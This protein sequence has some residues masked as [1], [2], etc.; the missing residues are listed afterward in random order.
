MTS[1]ALVQTPPDPDE[2]LRLPGDD[3]ATAAIES[4]AVGDGQIVR[5]VQRRDGRSIASAV[6]IPTE[7][8]FPA[9]DTPSGRFDG[10]WL[11]SPTRPEHPAEAVRMTAADLF[12]GCGG[13]TLGAWEAARAVGIDLHPVLAVDV[14]EAALAAYGENFS[15]AEL[16]SD[17]IES[18]LDGAL[19]SPPTLAERRLRARIGP[20]DLVLAGP[21][22]QGHSD[23][24]NHTR[25]D[26]P[27][28]ALYLR[29]ARFAEVFQPR[30]L[31]IENVPGVIH[32]KSNV[33]GETC[34]VL[35]GLGYS[36]HG[37]VLD[38]SEIGV[39]QRRRRYFVIA[40]P[41]PFAGL[42]AILER[43]RQ[44]E[45][46]V[47]WACGDLEECSSDTA[48]DS[49]ATHSDDNKRRIAY[50]FK[51]D[52]FE[53]PDA[54]RPDCHRLKSH[55]YKS[56]YGRMYPDRPAPTIT[57]GFL[58][59]GQGRFVHPNQPRTLTPHEAARL[60]F[61]PDFF[62]FGSAPRRTLQRMIGNAVPSKMAYIVALDLLR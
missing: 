9:G 51:H 17:P 19:G 33:V 5:T 62:Q 7:S 45:R 29:V 47:L 28:N 12:S 31:I 20:V 11:R 24:N 14:F 52:V 32:D 53:L 50:L 39:A 26:D 36:I 22:C 38:A 61:F 46:P 59:T 42:D 57:A 15:Q 56:V 60:Q 13:L 3:W 55:S 43:S 35:E 1:Y 34:K 48:F 54:E 6:S 2:Q 4:F 41:G 8:R 27:K 16:S 44:P 58:S 40:T 10:A 23:L 25:R 37:R 49:S 18:L 30:H 21:P